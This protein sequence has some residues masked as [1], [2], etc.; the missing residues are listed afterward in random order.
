MSAAEYAASLY[1]SVAAAVGYGKVPTAEPSETEVVPVMARTDTNDEEKG[2]SQRDNGHVVAATTPAAEDDSS[3]GLLSFYLMSY[4]VLLGDSTRGL[5]FPTLW[6]LVSSLGGTKTQQGIIVAAFSMG[7]VVVS[8]F[9]GWVSSRRGYRDVLVFAH[10]IVIL[11]ATWYVMVDSLWQLL[12]AQI[13]LGLGCGTL[14]VTRSY[15]AESV[16]RSQR[17]IFLGRLTAMQYAGF[18]TTPFLGSLMYYVGKRLDATGLPVD[19]L[20]FPAALIALG[21]VVACGLLLS[22]SFIEL[23]PER[24]RKVQATHENQPSRQPVDLSRRSADIFATVGLVL[25]VITKGSIGCYETIG[26][27]YAQQA[28]GASG[29]TVGY[30]VALCGFCGVCALL[31]FKPLSRCFDDVQLMVGGIAVMLF[32]CVLLVQAVR[33]AGLSIQTEESLWAVAVF[34]MYAVGYPIGHT[35]VIGWFSKT[36][37]KRPQGL[38]MGLFASAGSVARV[39]FPIFTGIVAQRLGTDA[40]FLSLLALLSVTILVVSCYANKFRDAAN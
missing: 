38:L 2:S 11:G 34:A 3:E 12:A 37:G 40:V 21:A 13:A 4:V 35:A 25:N 10:V 20:S 29:P 31:S 36:M 23:S 19:A 9:Y 16:P 17:T 18:T 6:P 8:P 22:P 24:R 39:A 27:I 14:G 33:P 5:M 15:V 1:G 7:R 32:S 26:V 30:V 28:F